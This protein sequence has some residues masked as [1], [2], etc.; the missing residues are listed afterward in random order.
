MRLCPQQRSP[1]FVRALAGDLNSSRASL[2]ALKR[3]G[4]DRAKGYLIGNE[5]ETRHG[6]SP[7][8]TCVDRDRRRIGRV[9]ARR[10]SDVA[11]LVVPVGFG[12]VIRVTGFQCR[13]G[14]GRPPPGC[15]LLFLPPRGIRAYSVPVGG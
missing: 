7:Q 13:G 1:E 5:D 4:H 2:L 9:V 11:G 10:D 12:A 14:A 8:E 15:V 6:R 3:F